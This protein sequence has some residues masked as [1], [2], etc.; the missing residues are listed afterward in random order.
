[1]HYPDN[2]NPVIIRVFLKQMDQFEIADPPGNFD[3]Y[4][5]VYEFRPPIRAVIS[6]D[7]VSSGNSDPPHSGNSEPSSTSPKL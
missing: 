6:L 4:P 1:M 3:G 2:A 5:I 7:A